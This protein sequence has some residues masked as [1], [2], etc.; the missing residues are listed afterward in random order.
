MAPFSEFHMSAPISYGSGIYAIDSGYVRSGLAAIYLIIENG[1][2]ALIETGCND[3]V[4]FV[5]DALARLG[6]AKGCVDF[7]IPTHVHLDHAGGAGAM[8][9]A[10]PNARLVVHPRGARH[11]ADPSKLIAGTI[12]VYGEEATRRLYGEILPIEA[13]RIAEAK[14]DESVSLAGRQLLCL[15]VAGHAKHHIAIVDEKSGQIFT[16]DTFGVTYAELGDAERQFVFPTT[17]PV[18]FD[19]EALHASMNRLLSYRPDAVYPTHFGQLRDVQANGNTLHR[20]IDAFV[21]IA[22]QAMGSG[23][24]RHRQIRAALVRFALSEARAIG[25]GLP[26]SRILELLANDIELNAQGLGVW[27]DNQAAAS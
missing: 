16:G 26:E 5:L 15:D 24:E 22:R 23:D 4:P 11:M 7:V 25:C 18:Q 17:T 13:G 1:R 9:R 19:P 14:D 20:H 6:V 27:L 12:A 10:F 8:M 3:S 2:A 21:E